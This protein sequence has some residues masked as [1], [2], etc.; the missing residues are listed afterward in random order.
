MFTKILICLL[1][2]V[3]ITV[4][5]TLQLKEQSQPPYG[6]TV[7]NH[8]GIFTFSGVIDSASIH[9]ALNYFLDNDLEKVVIEIHSPGGSLFEVWR[10]IA[11]LE[12]HGD[13]LHYE[14][15]VYGVAG[16]GGFMVFLAGDERLI[17]RHAVFLW[18]NVEARMSAGDNKFFDDASNEYIASRTGM[19]FKQ[20]EE[21]ITNGER[22]KDWYFGAKEAIALGIAHG[23]I[24]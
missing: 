1:L 21:K 3:A 19:T 12:E 14:T 8:T 20:V 24:D 6:A 18:H 17:S 7:E 10:I 13:K 4:G 16:S 15:R 9:A 5:A 23:Y 11:L 22:K 2:I